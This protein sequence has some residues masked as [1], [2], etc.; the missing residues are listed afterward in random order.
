MSSSN[1]I[2]LLALFGAVV[3]VHW[4]GAP[5]IVFYPIWASAM[6]IAIWSHWW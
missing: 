1:V 3:G 4:A 5:D 6:V 2:A